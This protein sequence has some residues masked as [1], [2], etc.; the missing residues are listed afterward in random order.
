MKRLLVTTLS[1][2]PSIILAAHQLDD[3]FKNLENKYDGKIGIYTLNPEDK[4]NIKYNE[5]YHFPNCSV[6]KF[7]L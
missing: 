4:T 5:S 3:S 6:F 7:L 2:I 1:L